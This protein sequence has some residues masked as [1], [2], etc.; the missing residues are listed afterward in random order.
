ML[1]R[2]LSLLLIF[3]VIIL[4][5]RL[6][7]VSRVATTHN[8]VSIEAAAFA[9]W[10]YVFWSPSLHGSGLGLGLSRTGLNSTLSQVP[11]SC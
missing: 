11:G 3:V 6:C 1:Y 10:C 2:M 7:R 9:L 4:L 5:L 8:T